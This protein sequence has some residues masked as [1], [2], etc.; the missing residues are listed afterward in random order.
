MR[1]LDEL[2]D[3]DGLLGSVFDSN[4]S[5]SDLIMGRNEDV[6]GT[7]LQKCSG[8]FHQLLLHL[9]GNLMGSTSP[10][11]DTPCRMSRHIVN[12]RAGICRGN[13]HS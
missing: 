6:L 1:S 2:P 11:V 3:R 4:D 7:R 10:A 13:I 8:K 12:G 9:F 5:I